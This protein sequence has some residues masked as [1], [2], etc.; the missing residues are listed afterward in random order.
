[1]ATTDVILVLGMHRSGT[2]A[3]AGALTMLGGGK[4]KTM[5]PANATNANGFFESN[6]FMH[7]HD[8]LL[9]SAGTSW[10]DW[11]PFN[12]EWRASA[13]A[14]DF[15]R[16]AK[17]L[18]DEEFAHFPLPVF[19]DPRICRFAP[20]WLDVLAEMGAK[21]RIVAPLRSPL[22]VARSLKAIHGFSLTHGLLLW[23]RHTLDAEAQTRALPRSL[24][25][26]RD[27]QEDWR[28]VSARIAGETD[29]AWPRLSDRSRREIDQF[30]RTDLIHHDT[31]D[32]ALAGHGE[33]HEWTRRAY[34]A[35]L[36][37]SRNPQ[38]NSALATLDDVRQLLDQASGLFGRLLI[39]AEMEL[40]EAR[41]W[42]SAAA[43]E[44]EALTATHEAQLAE[45]GLRAEAAER[46]HEE[47]AM[48]AQGEALQAQDALSRALVEAFEQ[49]DAERA[50]REEL[51]A[52]LRR[53]QQEL[54]DQ[55][56]ARE[57]LA[58]RLATAEQTRD[59]AEHTKHAREIETADLA[60]RLAALTERFDAV[61][62]V[63]SAERDAERTARAELEATVRAQE[64]A[65]AE[66]A[67]ALSL[68]AEDAQRTLA[69][70]LRERDRLAT[71]LAGAAAE[72]LDLDDAL[73]R[74]REE[75]KRRQ[76]ENAET[77]A[78]LSS[79]S[80]RVAAAEQQSSD[81]ADRLNTSFADLQALQA[82]NNQL[83]NALRAAREHANEELSRLSEELTQARAEIEQART[84]A[85]EQ[86][87]SRS[88]SI[89]EAER[90][91]E[92]HLQS[93]RASLVDAE[94]GFARLNAEAHRKGL[95]RLIPASLKRR[96]VARR[97]LASGL[98]DADY[99]RQQFAKALSA[100]PA[101][102]RRAAL[103]A[104]EHYIEQ[105]F[106]LG[107][108][109][110]PLFDSRWYFNK[111]EDV[112]LAGVN[113]LLHYAHHGWREGRD[114]GPNFHTSYYLRSN[115]DVASKGINPLGHYL[116]HG[117]HEARRPTDAC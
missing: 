101:D 10:S 48:S 62:A 32:A 31:D 49:R 13:V 8:E 98:F 77:E 14:A 9:G 35:L 44:R 25:A 102:G 1:M 117:R 112:R 56:A 85:V 59:A 2:S 15:R 4:P 89:A 23:M 74:A 34:E 38:S 95:A 91:H 75:L 68:Q 36:E 20:F 105:G 79:V 26:W 65:L 50:A 18:F 110:N 12:P 103:A 22:D 115:P 21:A 6:A 97:L 5:M 78:A 41:G 63:S 42:A 40:E 76:V 86:E 114:P 60:A 94:A 83:S 39:D 107:G 88:R 109:P 51:D 111:Y 19:K 67:A 90:A 37:L 70:A 7:F 3:V 30:L 52:A 93:L 104:A 96:R 87:T 54:A 84:L 72:R 61:V 53:S 33:V 64:Q 17:S 100:A 43:S 27:F 106:H 99:Y 57:D 82:T 92:A 73:A 81:L 71:A 55:A 108:K 113:P 45:L 29:L 16:R 47:A 80:A 116:Q 66:R 28:S 46:A 58:Q 24:F 69:D 11:R